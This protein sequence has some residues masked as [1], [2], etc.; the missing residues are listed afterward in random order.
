[1][2]KF[3]EVAE[4]VGKVIAYPFTRT[5]QFVYVIDSVIKDSPIVRNDL[6]TLVKNAETVIAECTVVTGE[7]GINLA[8]DLKALQAAEAFFTYFKGTFLPEV[9]SVYN[10]LE[11]DTK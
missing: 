5:A 9:E 6:I 7:K 3:E 8:D 11:T 2:N 1:M 10:D 4:D